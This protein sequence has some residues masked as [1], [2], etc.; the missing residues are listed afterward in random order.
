VTTT[1]CVD[2][3]ATGT[4]YYAVAAVDRDP[5]G[6]LR[7]G[8]LS[9]PVT[10]NPSNSPPN[11][12]KQAG[13]YT[14]IAN[15]IQW[16]AAKTGDVDF[17]YIYRDSF[18]GRADRYDSISNGGFPGSIVWTDPDPGGVAHK[19]WV[20]AVDFNMAASDPAPGDPPSHYIQ[21]DASGTTC[22]VQ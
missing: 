10:I 17:Y 13:C 22:N 14:G 6:N 7:V 18:T 9:T 4:V 1:N 8:P 12:P 11:V 2:Q 19:Y 15:S 20:V 21:W 3:D 16:S 5:S